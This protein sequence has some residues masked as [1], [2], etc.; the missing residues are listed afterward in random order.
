MIKLY[1]VMYFIFG[2]HLFQ[3][4]CVL[5]GE[6]SKKIRRFWFCKINQSSSKKVNI[7]KNACFGVNI[8]LGDNS[9]IGKNCYVQN[10]VTIGSNV[11]MAPDCLIY[12]INHCYTDL[13][14][15]IVLQG[16]IEKSVKIGNNVWIGT[17]T[18]I[19]PGVEIG[20]NV[21]IGAGS[22]VT[23]DIPSNTM[24]AG[25]PCVVKKKLR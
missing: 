9:G 1:K 4:D 22:V 13:D 12:T 5:L 24:A 7:D 17:R 18:I 16:I 19:L 3:S 8:K 10:N 2:K 23:K 6:I 20:D 21:V 25:N 11:L 14:K 15:P